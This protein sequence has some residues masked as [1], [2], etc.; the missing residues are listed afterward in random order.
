MPAASDRDVLTIHLIVSLSFQNK[1]Q[2]TKIRFRI[3]QCPDGDSEKVSKLLPQTRISHM[4]GHMHKHV[5]M[6]NED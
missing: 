5:H 1:M 3:H 4:H 2:N 6:E